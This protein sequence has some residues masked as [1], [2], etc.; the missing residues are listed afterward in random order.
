MRNIFIVYMPPNNLEA[1]AHYRDTIQHKVPLE[2]VAKFLSRD[3]VEK[4]KSVFGPR[5]IAVWGSRDGPQNCGRFERMLEGDDLL[6]VEGP[7]IRFIGKI[8]LKVVSADLSRELWANL[9]PQE[10]TANW[11]LIYFIANPLELNVPF[12]TFCRLFNYSEMFQL[13]GFTSVSQDKVLEFYEKFDDL[14]SI[15]V[16]EDKHEPIAQKEAN[17]VSRPDP[18]SHFPDEADAIALGPILSEHVSMQCKLAYMGK[19]AGQKI[20]VPKADQSRL[21]NACNFSEFEPEFSTGIDLPKAYFENI[22]V[23]W[24]E[25]YRIDA[26]FEVENSTAIYSGLLRFADLNVV[27]PNTIYPM[28]IVAPSDRRNKVRSQVQRQVFRKLGFHQKVKLLTYEAVERVEQRFAVATT[29][30]SVKAL[31]SESE[32]FDN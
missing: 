11:N 16:R 4:L 27:A 20:W 18:D 17:L 19:K 23:V 7:N 24:K 26:V 9:N 10:P 3:N 32:S 14:Y 28:F 5:R 2:R 6:I 31:E 30:F 21:R 1:M 13:K 8:A 15:L 12:T 22:D 29:G 25:E